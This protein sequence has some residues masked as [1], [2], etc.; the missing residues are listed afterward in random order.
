MKWDFCIFPSH[1][2]QIYCYSFV[3][4]KR[5]S[6][7][8]KPRL[9]SSFSFWRTLLLVVS[10]LTQMSHSLFH[11]ISLSLFSFVLTGVDVN[12]LFNRSLS[13]TITSLKRCPLCSPPNQMWGHNTEA[14]HT[15]GEERTAFL[16][17][18][19]P[20]KYLSIVLSQNMVS[21]FFLSDPD[22]MCG[23]NLC[24]WMSFALFW[25]QALFF[26]LTT[27]W[28]VNCGFV[29]QWRLSNQLRKC[30]YYNDKRAWFEILPLLFLICS[31]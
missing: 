13:L 4:S 26:S 11:C 17:H 21:T 5:Y 24:A 14:S 10:Q 23:R 8:T 31:L 16:V 22:I 3:N 19:H 9:D 29:A 6:D 7:Q 20:G 1:V 28:R 27:Q 15:Y 25:A 18:S 30:N 2:K 12:Y